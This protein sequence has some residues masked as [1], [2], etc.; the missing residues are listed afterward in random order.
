[1]ARSQFEAM[2]LGVEVR[3]DAHGVPAGGRRVLARRWSCP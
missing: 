2:T 3:R 1:M